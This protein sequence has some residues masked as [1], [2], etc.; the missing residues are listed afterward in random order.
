MVSTRFIFTENQ[1]SLGGVSAS[2][3]N[4]K[5]EEG[6]LESTSCSS[7]TSTGHRPDTTGFTGLD[8]AVYTL[9]CGKD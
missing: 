9:S 7:L 2:E 5:R 6:V 4:P 1:S 8:W 3:N